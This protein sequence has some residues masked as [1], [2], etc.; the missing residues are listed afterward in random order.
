MRSGFINL[1]IICSISLASPWNAGEG[2]VLSC[3]WDWGGGFASEDFT[4][5]Q[6][7]DMST[8][9]RAEV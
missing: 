9:G 8:A 1:L 7:M 5:I 6:T 4:K 3:I 2:L